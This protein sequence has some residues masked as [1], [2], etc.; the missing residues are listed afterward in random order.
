VICY[1]LETVCHCEPSDTLIW[2][3]RWRCP[4]CDDEMALKFRRSH[5]LICQWRERLICAGLWGPRLSQDAATWTAHQ[6]EED[7]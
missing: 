1:C 7:E 3:G 4:V 6:P 2:R 5:T